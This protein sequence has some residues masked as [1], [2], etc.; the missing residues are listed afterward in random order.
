MHL[1]AGESPHYILRCQRTCHQVCTRKAQSYGKSHTALY[2]QCPRRRRYQAELSAARCVS[3]ER[4]L[5][6]I[7]SRAE[8][9]PCGPGRILTSRVT[10]DLHHPALQS[11][12]C[13]GKEGLASPPSRTPSNSKTLGIQEIPI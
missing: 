13:K 5:L 3:Q 6:L 7:S 12:F 9:Q 4:R 10:F 11:P 2:K 8:G 1:K